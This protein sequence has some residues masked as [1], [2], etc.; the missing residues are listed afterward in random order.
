MFDDKET[1]IK[2]IK[3]ATTDSDMEVKFDE[4]NKPGISNLLNIASVMTGKNISELE[5]EFIGKNYGEF[6]TY[7]GEV[8]ASKIEEIQT[9]YSSII[10]SGELDRILDKGADVNSTNSYGNTALIF[11][12]DSYI[13]N[14]DIIKLLLDNGAD[15]N[16]KNNCGKYALNYALDTGNENIIKLISEKSSMDVI[17]SILINNI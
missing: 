11:A 9:R 8:T 3:G 15:V 12:L 7:V 14:E 5:N 17:N 1:I 4:E 16:I 13:L 2:K 6:K 10:E